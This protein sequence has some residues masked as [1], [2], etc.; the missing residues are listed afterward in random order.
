MF[1]LTLIT[2]QRGA[3]LPAGETTRAFFTH[4]YESSECLLVLT[5]YFHFKEKNFVQNTLAILQTS[6]T[7][8]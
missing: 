6:S 8:F 2:L 5:Q 4:L 3:N 7:K 1:Y